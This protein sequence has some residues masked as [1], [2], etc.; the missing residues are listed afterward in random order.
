M[1]LRMRKR[2]FIGL[3]G[4]AAA[5]PLAARGQQQPMRRLGILT[6]YSKDDR[7]GQK[8]LNAFHEELLKFGWI[9]GRNILTEYR[10]ASLEANS[11][12]QAARELVDWRPDVLFTA[13]TATAT[14]LGQ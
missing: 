4:G 13:S 14:A 8:R 9:E 1:G 2:E 5:W 3:V 10:R 6:T 12:R 11:L 7:E